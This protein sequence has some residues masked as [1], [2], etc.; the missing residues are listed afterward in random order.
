MAT[1]SVYD[2]DSGLTKSVVIDIDSAV[3]NG[4]RTGSRSYYITVTINARD[5][6]GNAISPIVL[7]DGDITDDISTAVKAAI[8][9]LF[10]YVTGVYLDETSSSS[11]NELSTSSQT[12]STVTSGMSSSSSSTRRQGSS[13]SVSSESSHSVSSVSSLSSNT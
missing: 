8:V 10:R 4:S 11:T 6:R 13:S 9:E 5:P 3:I 1:I 12:V 7:T 2:S